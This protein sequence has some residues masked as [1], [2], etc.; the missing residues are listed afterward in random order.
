[1]SVWYQSVLLL[2]LWVRQNQLTLMLDQFCTPISARWADMSAYVIPFPNRSIIES[3]NGSSDAIAD[4]MRHGCQYIY[5]NS[6]SGNC[7]RLTALVK[8]SPVK[9]FTSFYIRLTN[10]ITASNHILQM[11]TDGG[12]P[13]LAHCQIVWNWVVVL[14]LASK[15]MG[16]CVSMNGCREKREVQRPSCWNGPKQGSTLYLMYL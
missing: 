10:P 7:K 2:W 13:A 15:P 12:T 11:L 3:V 8:I 14:T 6:I 4:P 9:L 5:S 1:M 16:N